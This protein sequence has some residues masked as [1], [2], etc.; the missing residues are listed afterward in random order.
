V[1][2]GLDEPFADASVLPTFL[3]SRFTRRSVTVALGGDGSDELLAGY[4]TFPAEAVA[5]RYRIRRAVHDR[6]LL[7]IAQRLPVSTADFSLDFK[8]KHFLRGVAETPAIR[9]QLWLGA[10]APAEERRLA[11]WPLRSDPY[12]EVRKLYGERAQ[13]DWI[14]RLIYL[15][16]KTYLQDD[17]LVKVDRASMLSSLEVR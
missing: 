7:P 6:L 14:G 2:G 16:A 11:M 9:H 12:S 4:P 13:G 8:L 5:R 15:Y 17:I 3:L 1:L 10:F